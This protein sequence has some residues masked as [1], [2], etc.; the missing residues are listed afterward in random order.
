[1]S[2]VIKISILLLILSFGCRAVS[3]RNSGDTKIAS[4][5]GFSIHF[6]DGFAGDTVSLSIDDEVIFSRIIFPPEQDYLSSD[7]FTDPPSNIHVKLENNL[8]EIR[9][10]GKDQ[11]SKTFNEKRVIKLLVK[12]GKREA[13]FL[14]DLKKGRYLVVEDFEYYGNM[15]VKT[16]LF[17]NGRTRSA[18]PDT[19]QQTTDYGV[20][21]VQLRLIQSKTVFTRM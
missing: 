20:E 2:G 10:L 19:E 8:L 6:Y 1:M 17:I 11:S 18:K 9:L 4:K 12:D 14:V 5:Y 16:H 13:E 7:P 3:V 21:N 15:L